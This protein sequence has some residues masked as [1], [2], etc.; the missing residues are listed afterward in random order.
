MSGICSSSSM[1]VDGKERSEGV[2]LI[3][4]KTFRARSPG[5]LLLLL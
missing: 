3:G 5:L 1:G 2:L 4:D